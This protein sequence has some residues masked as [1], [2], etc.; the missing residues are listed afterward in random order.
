MGSWMPDGTF[1]YASVLVVTVEK[2]A[3]LLNDPALM[4]ALSRIRNSPEWEQARL[5]IDLLNGFGDVLVDSICSIYQ[6]SMSSPVS[7]QAA[8]KVLT[9]S[10]HF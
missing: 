7:F 2:A 8:P 5:L 3:A 4:E 9:A 1:G 6:Q 10:H